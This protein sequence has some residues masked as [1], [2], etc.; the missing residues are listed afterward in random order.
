M[1]GKIRDKIDECP[2]FGFE[3]PAGYFCLLQRELIGFMGTLSRLNPWYYIPKTW[4]GKAY[5]KG[6]VTSYTGEGDIFPF[7]RR[8]DTDDIACFEVVN[9]CVERIISIHGWT[10]TG[11]EV[12]AY[13]SSF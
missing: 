10:P 8:M 3:P 12:R 7:A 5:E 11:H 13:H 1:S 9:G 6:R 2:D 4:A